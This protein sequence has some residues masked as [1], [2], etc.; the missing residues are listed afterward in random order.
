ML[1]GTDIPE[2]RP[3]SPPGLGLAADTS[4]SVCWKSELRA[5]RA[6]SFP[7]TQQGATVTR[8]DGPQGPEKW[9]VFSAQPQNRPGSQA[10]G[11]LGPPPR[12]PLPDPRLQISFRPQTPSTLHPV[13]PGWTLLRKKQRTAPR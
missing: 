6:S 5:R 1:L 8:E 11:K 12:L 13:R 2:P 3:E 9:A 10:V 4:A 7:A